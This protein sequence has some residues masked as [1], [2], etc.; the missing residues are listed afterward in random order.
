MLITPA[1][2]E[3][4]ISTMS[5]GLF[6]VGADGVILLCNPAFERLTGYSRAECVGTSC[7]RL[8]C[9]MCKKARDDGGEAWCVMFSAKTEDRKQC[10]IRHK[11]GAWLPVIK[12]ARTLRMEGEGMCVVETLTDISGLLEREQRIVELSRLLETEIGLEGLI[13]TAPVMRHI[14]RIL[15]QSAASDAPVL[16]LGESGTGKELAAHAVHKLSARR[17]QPYVSVHCAALN[18][19]VLESELFGHVRG[20]FTGANRD[21]EGRF[22]AAD[23]GTLFLDE[24]GDTPLMTQVKLLRVLETGRYE[25]VGENIS[26]VADV[27]LVAATNRPLEHLVRQGLF[28]EDLFFRINVIPIRLPPLR[29]HMEDLPLLAGHLLERIAKRKKIEAPKLTVPALDLLYAHSWPGNVREL[30]NALE[31]AVAQAGSQ[32]IGAEHL[33]PFSSHA[34]VLARER[35][36]V[37]DAG[38]GEEQLPPSAEENARETV[39]TALDACNGNI[40]CA[41]RLLGIHRSTL[42]ARLHRLGIRRGTHI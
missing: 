11:D 22:G 6:V 3:Q 8:G 2:F 31:Y 42:H 20:A 37:R 23:K 14:Y 36:V 41:A 1:F 24:I 13:G 17:D 5:E 26:R 25:A 19:A 34:S 10:T 28:R 18:E 38:K 21:R 16:L 27:R 29:E 12:N 32:S 40:S 39:L 7:V 30:R 9:D 33:P 35:G 15:E 4:L